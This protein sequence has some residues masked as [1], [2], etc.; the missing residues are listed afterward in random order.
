ME[1]GCIKF[2]DRVDLDAQCKAVSELA[3]TAAA[4]S[5]RQRALKHRLPL[6]TPVAAAAAVA[7]NLDTAYVPSQL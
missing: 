4:W 2:W 5:A 3:A 1:F 6:A 7:S